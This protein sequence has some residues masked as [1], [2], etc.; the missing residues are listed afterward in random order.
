MIQIMEK[1]KVEVI[2]VVEKDGLIRARARAEAEQ[3]RI[4]V[5]VQ[6]RLTPENENIWSKSRSE[7]LKYLDLA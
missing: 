6:F 3:A 4:W 7:V 5:E 2:S 1:M